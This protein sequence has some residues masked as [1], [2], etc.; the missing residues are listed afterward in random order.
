MKTIIAIAIAAVAAA[1]FVSSA[2]SA[3]TDHYVSGYEKANG[4]YVAPHYQTNPNATTS[5]NYSTRGNVNP[6]TGQ[7]GTKPD[8]R[9]VGGY[10]APYSNPYAAPNPYEQQ[11]PACTSLYGC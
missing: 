3:Q 2:A 6:Y 1:L 5:D 7:M 9:P 8:S 4:I 10:A 11:K